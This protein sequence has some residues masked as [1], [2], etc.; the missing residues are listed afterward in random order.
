MPTFGTVAAANG[1]LRAYGPRRRMIDRNQR[2]RLAARIRQD[3]RLTPGARLVWHAIAFAFVGSRAYS[4]P[5]FEAIARHAGMSRATVARAVPEL[6][7]L[8]YLQ[9]FRSYGR[10]RDRRGR[11]TPRREPNRYSIPVPHESHPA[12]GTKTEIIKPPPAPLPDDLAAVL[13]RLGTAIA[14][15]RGGIQDVGGGSRNVQ[16]TP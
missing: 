11:P 1:A 10:R 9:V 2:A 5:G 15:R 16:T 8:G 14:D 4:Y 6:E 13:V 7:R 3:R 12:T